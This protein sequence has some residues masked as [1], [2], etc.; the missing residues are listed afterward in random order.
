MCSLWNW[1]HSF[2]IVRQ[3]HS[4]NIQFS[5]LFYKEQSINL[6]LHTDSKACLVQIL[7][8]FWLWS[9]EFEFYWDA[10]K[11]VPYLNKVLCT[12]IV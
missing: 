3:V 6:N 2:V 9:M 7:V 12:G 10:V 5:Y 11:S 8:K 4:F 1:I